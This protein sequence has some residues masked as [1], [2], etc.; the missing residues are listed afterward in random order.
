MLTSQATCILAEEEL[1]NLANTPSEQVIEQFNFNEKNFKKLKE[2]N[3]K[4]E[5]ALKEKNYIKFDG[6][7]TETKDIQ[8]K[9]NQEQQKFIDQT[10]QEK[11]RISKTPVHKKGPICKTDTGQEIELSGTIRNV[12]ISGCNLHGQTIDSVT[13]DGSDLRGVNFQ[14]SNIRNV[15][16]INKSRLSGALFSGATIT[17]T[18]FED[19]SLYCAAFFDATLQDSESRN[20]AAQI[21][22]DSTKIKLTDKN[23][24]KFGSV[25]LQGANFSGS[26]LI[27]VAFYNSS[28]KS[29]NIIRRVNFSQTEL[30]NV[31]FSQE[32]TLEL[33]WFIASEGSLVSFGI[34]AQ[35]CAKKEERLSRFFSMAM[36]TTGR[37]TWTGET[38]ENYKPNLAM[39]FFDETEFDRLCMIGDGGSPLNLVGAT[40][41]G[42]VIKEYARFQSIYCKPPNVLCVGKRP[43]IE[44]IGKT[45][46][47]MKKLDENSKR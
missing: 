19:V 35:E 21:V 20:N 25:D 31:S 26:R 5:Q 24:T 11:E 17:N 41:T 1:K 13:F 34:T 45:E 7:V 12:N 2:Q 47:F 3:E 6:I 44:L 18:I 39:T 43:A 4:A 14:V 37:T 27:N 40:S 8:K 29:P 33:A 22:D 30:H 15:K 10:K 28:S 46:D 23:R 38:T 16:F 42:S 36:G 9:I 32:T